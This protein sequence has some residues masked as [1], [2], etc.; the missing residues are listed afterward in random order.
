[1]SP[2]RFLVQAQ[3]GR[4]AGGRGVRVQ[5]RTLRMPDDVW[6]QLDGLSLDL[7]LQPSLVVGTLIRQA[8]D[9]LAAH[10]ASTQAT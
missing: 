10:V 5:A 1:M 3:D 9:E 7:C 8:S 2:R 4:A 6:D